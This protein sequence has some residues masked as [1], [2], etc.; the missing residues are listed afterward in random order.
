MEK[1]EILTQLAET[2]AAH[3]AEVTAFAYDPRAFGNIAVTVKRGK[4][5][6]AFVTDR[7]EIF[8]NGCLCCDA[9]YHV[10]GE[11]DTHKKLAEIMEMLLKC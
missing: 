6:Y 4:K 8:C 5:K 1:E 10:A 3:G 7:G 11:D 2:A 9:L